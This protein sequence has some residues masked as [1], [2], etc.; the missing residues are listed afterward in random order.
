[1]TRLQELEA[2]AFSVFG[3]TNAEKDEYERLA[4]QAMDERRNQRRSQV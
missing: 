1:M 4:Q 3:L 2:K